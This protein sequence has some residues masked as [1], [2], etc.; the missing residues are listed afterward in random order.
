MYCLRSDPRESIR[1]EYEGKYRLKIEA[2]TNPVALS[3]EEASKAFP[4]VYFNKS[5]CKNAF[6]VIPKATAFSDREI[7]DAFVFCTAQKKST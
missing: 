7:P 1:D 6:V 5:I 4:N 2:K 3:N